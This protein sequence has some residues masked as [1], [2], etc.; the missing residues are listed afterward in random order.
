MVDNIVYGF[1]EEIRVLSKITFIKLLTPTGYVQ[2]TVKGGGAP[3]GVVDAAK[4]LTR[5]SY[6]AAHGELKDNPSVKTGPEMLPEKIEIISLSEEPL[7]LDPS[8]KTFAELDTRLDWRSI[9]LRSPKN[10]AIFTVQSKIVESMAD[11][12]NKNRFVQIFTPGLIGTASE[13]GS[14]VFAVKYFDK[15]VFLRQDPQLHRDLALVGGLD[16]VFEIGPSWRAE[17]SHT[18]RHMCEH[19]T[20]AVELANV[21][22]ETDVMKL[23]EDFIRHVVKRVAGEC[24]SELKLFGASLE[25]PKSKFP[26]IKF[27]EIYDL[28]AKLGK[29]I[30]RG[31][32]YDRESEEL[33]GKYVKEEHG[34]DFYFTDGFPFSV[35]PFYVVKMED[36]TWARSVDLMFRG[37][38]ISTGGQR[39]HRYEKLMA[40]AKEKKM[41]LKS[42]EWFTKFFRYGSPTLGGF[43]MGIERLTMQMLGVKNVREATLYPRTPERI[44]P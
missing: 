31:D 28:L 35:K 5:Q 24:E 19:R 15:E 32:D 44:L 29:K 41:D 14:D 33:L 23:E 38:E 18:T 10:R 22:D 40:Q 16:R 13:G 1:V 42:I 17:L 26:V 11:Y 30:P 6:I 37:M 2:L 9:D 25:L 27:P 21:K 34:S 20:C 39:E 3:R 43:S 4:K 7:P 36:P 8:G 12:L